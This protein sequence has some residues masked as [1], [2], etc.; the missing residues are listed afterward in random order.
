[1][2]RPAPLPRPLLRV[3]PYDVHFGFECHAELFL[4]EFLCLLDEVEDVLGGCVPA[5]YE[6]VRV[7][8]GHFCS[9]D[10]HALGA[11]GFEQSSGVVA[12]GAF[13]DG[14]GAG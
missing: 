11:G 10:G 12:F 6:E 8:A 13:E 4:H 7:F 5:V 1:M 3:F 14:P 9:A 2:I